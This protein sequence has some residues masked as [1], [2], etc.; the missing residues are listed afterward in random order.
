MAAQSR[1]ATPLL[2]TDHTQTQPRSRAGRGPALGGVGAKRSEVKWRAKPA[3]QRAS[4]L[5]LHLESPHPACIRR[6]HTTEVFCSNTSPPTHHPH[7]CPWSVDGHPGPPH[8][9]PVHLAPIPHDGKGDA[10]RVITTTARSGG[11]VRVPGM[12]RVLELHEPRMPP[13][14]LI[15]RQIQTQNKGAAHQVLAHRHT[16]REGSSG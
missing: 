16:E 5:T 6:Q 4:L 12:H 14:P 1:A 10:C 13:S 11:G 2:A 3:C 15:T 8:L 9:H 7:P